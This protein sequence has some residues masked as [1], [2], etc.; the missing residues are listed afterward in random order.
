[1]SLAFLWESRSTKS[2]AFSELSEEFGPGSYRRSNL[3][4]SEDSEEDGS[5][6]LGPRLGRQQEVPVWEDDEAL[7]LQ[8][9][10]AQREQLSRQREEH[11]GGGDGNGG[12]ERDALSP[13]N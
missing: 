1:M 4:D 7:Y 8:D 13:A 10:E 12:S 5:D 6:F 9:L 3:S 2:V 11:Q